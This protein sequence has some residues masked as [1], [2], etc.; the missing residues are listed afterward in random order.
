MTDYAVVGSSR[1][2]NLKMFLHTHTKIMIKYWDTNLL[3]LEKDAPGPLY[4]LNNTI[5]IEVYGHTILN[6]PNLV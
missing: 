6:S 3:N 4:L 2:K 1:S 5:A